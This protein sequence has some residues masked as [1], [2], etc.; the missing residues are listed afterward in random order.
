VLHGG[1]DCHATAA[2]Y[3]GKHDTYWGEGFVGSRT[4]TGVSKETELLAQLGFE[5]R[6]AY[7]DYTIREL[8][9]SAHV[10]APE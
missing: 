9:G 10:E 1:G 6:D 4:S 8:Q 3:L 5:L 2:L 7:G